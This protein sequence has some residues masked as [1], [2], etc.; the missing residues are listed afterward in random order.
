[1]VAPLVDSQ[2][3]SE[4][5]AREEQLPND[6]T[7]QRPQAPA[8]P[9]ALELLQAFHLGRGC[10]RAHDSRGAAAFLQ[11]TRLPESGPS[12]GAINGAAATRSA[13]LQRLSHRGTYMGMNGGSRRL[14][15]KSAPEPAGS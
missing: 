11:A 6:E 1:M 12:L 8:L 2:H 3:A 9:G 5:R 7:A 4:G 15:E 10:C 13:R 14:P